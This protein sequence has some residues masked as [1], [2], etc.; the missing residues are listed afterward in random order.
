MRGVTGFVT[1]LLAGADVG[2]EYGFD[3]ERSFLTIVL[4][5]EDPMPGCLGSDGGRVASARGMLAGLV[6]KR[7]GNC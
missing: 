1:R 5:P 2:L 6:L 7:A 4:G 3:V